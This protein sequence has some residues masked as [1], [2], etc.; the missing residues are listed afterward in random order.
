MNITTF[1]K[2][3]L[4]VLLTLFS[5][6]YCACMV[7]TLS[8]SDSCASFTS[9]ST[10]SSPSLFS[11]PFFSS[12]D[13]SYGYDY[14]RLGSCPGVWFAIFDWG[15]PYFASLFNSG[16]TAGLFF[17]LKTLSSESDSESSLSE[18]LSF[19]FFWSYSYT[20]WFLLFS[21][22]DLLPRI[23]ALGERSVSD[24]TSWFSTFFASSLNFYSGSLLLSK[25]V[26]TLVFA[27]SWKFC[28]GCIGFG[29]WGGGIAPPG[30]CALYPRGAISG[31]PYYPWFCG[32]LKVS[33][34]IF[35]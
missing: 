19:C 5:V 12:S 6:L 28:G 18:L 2:L 23:D 35:G 34:A 29:T 24:F 3:N 17:W 14:T 27:Y 31:L 8:S 13:D 21:T 15:S 1:C 30:N 9:T 10:L 25:F 33:A 11:S 22:F 7:F 4:K 26:G 32:P 20:S 16:F